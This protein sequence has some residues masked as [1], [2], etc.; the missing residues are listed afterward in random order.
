MPVLSIVFIKT[1]LIYFVVGFI[2]GFIMLLNKAYNF[3][4]RILILLPIHIQILFLGWTLEFV[5][6][7]AFWILP[8]FIYSYGRVELAWGS[9]FLLNIGILLSVVSYINTIVAFTSQGKILFI[10]SALLIF[11]GVMLFAFYIWSRVKPHIIPEMEK[12]SES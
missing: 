10:S 3:D 11:G 5:F 7:V 6:G 2:L 8:R 4:A 9:Y 1:A 12:S